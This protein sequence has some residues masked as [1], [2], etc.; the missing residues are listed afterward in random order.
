M[1]ESPK[2]N[3]DATMK[4]TV[5]RFLASPSKHPDIKPIDILIIA[6]LMTRKAEDHCVW[7]SHLTLARMFNTDDKT[8]SRSLTRLTKVGYISQQHRKGRTSFYALNYQTIPGEESL[9]AKISQPAKALAAKY[10]MILQKKGRKKF[11]TTW[12]GQ[13]FLCAQ[14]IIDKCKGDAES[15]LRVIEFA[16]AQ[17]TFRKRASKSLYNLFRLWKQIAPAYNAHR[18]QEKQQE[19]VA[20]QAQATPEGT[21]MEAATQ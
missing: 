19:A 15:A 17:T 16:L 1:S 6:H 9:K 13:Q 21:A 14:R 8:I 10:Q 12:L 5:T 3:D 7:P 18:K 2:M 20:S 4:V 11:P